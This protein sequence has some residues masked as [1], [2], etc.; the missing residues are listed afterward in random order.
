MKMLHRAYKSAVDTSKRTGVG[1]ITVPFQEEMEEIFGYNPAMSSTRL[2]E[3]GSL[4]SYF[5]GA[6]LLSVARTEH[7]RRS[8]TPCSSSGSS[9]R[10][11]TPTSTGPLSPA[12]KRSKISNNEQEKE[13][14][15]QQ[16]SALVEMETKVAKAKL[17]FFN[18]LNEKN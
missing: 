16:I 15:V 6:E 2:S 10:S 8:G 12:P 14:L 17:Q 3:P 4:P 1:R 7:L 11:M 9:R 18:K 5:A 13:N